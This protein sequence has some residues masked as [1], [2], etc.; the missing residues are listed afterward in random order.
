MVQKLPQNL[1]K[2]P[3]YTETQVRDAAG[4]GQCIVIIY[5][6]VYDLTDFLDEHPGGAE[7]IYEM[8]SILKSLEVASVRKFTQT[9][10]LMPPILG[11]YGRYQCFRGRRPQQVGPNR[12][13]PVRHWPSGFQRETHSRTSHQRY[14]LSSVKLYS[15]LNWT[16]SGDGY[17]RQPYGYSLF[18]SMTSQTLTSTFCRRISFPTALLFLFI[19]SLFVVIDSPRCLDLF[20]NGKCEYTLQF[21]VFNIQIVNINM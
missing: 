2:L 17:R 1:Q 16:A 5:D 15:R 10:L 6:L 18:S 12:N 8:V 13:A 11:R 9:Q 7:V 3:E 4:T 21:A 14:T 20:F 19:G